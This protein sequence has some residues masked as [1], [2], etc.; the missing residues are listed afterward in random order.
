MQNKDD[1]KELVGPFIEASEASDVDKA[2]DSLYDQLSALKIFGGG[3]AKASASGR[4]GTDGPA[5]LPT[6]L[7]LSIDHLAGAE[8]ASSATV[9]SDSGEKGAPSSPLDSPRRCAVVAV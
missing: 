2:M 9:D 6:P 5:K 7:H 4:D 8:P 1:F 3:S